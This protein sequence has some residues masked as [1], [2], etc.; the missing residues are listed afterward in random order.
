M[1]VTKE[2]K[3]TGV[4]KAV[5]NQGSSFESFLEEEGL[6]DVVDKVAVKRVLNWRTHNEPGTA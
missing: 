5:V 6:L 2:K 4:R 1:K 3:L